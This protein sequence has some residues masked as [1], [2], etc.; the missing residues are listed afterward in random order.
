MSGIEII[1][2]SIFLVG[3]GVAV[4]I[5]I[6]TQIKKGQKESMDHFA[7]KLKEMR[8]AF[9]RDRKKLSR[10]KVSKS[11]CAELRSQCACGIK[12]ERQ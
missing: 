1:K 3:V 10:E 4:P 7:E 12:K 8:K 9:K 11:E 2:D 6:I 5:W